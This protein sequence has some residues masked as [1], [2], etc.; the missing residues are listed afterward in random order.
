MKLIHHVGPRKVNATKKLS[1]EVPKMLRDVI[2]MVNFIK[3]RPLKLVEFLLFSIIRWGMIM[4]C[5]LL[6]VWCLFWGTALRVMKLTDDCVFFLLQRRQVFQICPLS[7]NKWFS[8]TCFLE[9]ISANNNNMRNLSLQGKDD[10]LTVHKKVTTIRETHAMERAFQ[11]EFL[12][13]FP[14]LH[15]F[16]FFCRIGVCQQKVL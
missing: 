4:K 3:I 11:N 14:Y 7:E 12:E 10:V 16:F 1:T 13:M 9:G 2:S 8:A 6:E 15:D 5:S